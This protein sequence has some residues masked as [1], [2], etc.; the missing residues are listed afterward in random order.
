MKPFFPERAYF[1]P[2]SLNYPLGQKLNKLF[3][4]RGIETHVMISSKIYNAIPADNIREKYANAKRTLIVSVKKGNVL[5]KCKPSADYE[6]SISS[7]CPAN[8]EYCY[9]YTVKSR[10]PYIRVF[11]NLEDILA[12]VEDYIKK[13]EKKITTFEASSLSDPLSVEHLTGNLAKTI[14][15][16]GKKENARLRVVSKYDNVDSLLN[17]EHNG[18]TKFRFSVNSRYVI[19]NFEHNSAS[20]DERI[21]ALSKIFDAGYPTGV[22]I[23][24]IMIYG[25]WKEEYKEL[26]ETLAKKID[27][28]K[29]L[30]PF[31]FEMIQHRFTKDAKSTILERFPGTKLDMDEEKRILKWGKFGRFKYVYPSEISNEM[32]EYISKLIDENF[33]NYVIEYFT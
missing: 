9:L 4:D 13:S 17:I 22:I 25:N 2:M 3:K 30:E 19:K 20:F 8:C 24:P 12:L 29:C 7:N 1:E 31:S 11:V 21:T 10:K 26:I 33:S 15:F 5:Y 32:K 16:F 6:F 18:H 23:A 14:S 28:K 27:S